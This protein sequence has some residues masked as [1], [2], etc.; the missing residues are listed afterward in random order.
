ML[1]KIL[2]DKYKVSD[3]E[4]NKK[5]KEIKKQMGDNFKT[6]ENLVYI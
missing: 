2:L 6:V 1:N 4:A 3:E 5:L